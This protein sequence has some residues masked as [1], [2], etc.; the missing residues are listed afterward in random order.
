M[1]STF[2]IS[3]DFWTRDYPD[4]LKPGHPPVRS[5]VYFNGTPAARINYLSLNQ[6]L[7]S[8]FLHVWSQSQ[9]QFRAPKT[10]DELAEFMNLELITISTLFKVSDYAAP[11]VGG[12]S[13]V[14]VI[15]RPPG[16]VTLW[17]Y[18]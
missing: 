17:P 3:E 13:Q 2:T 10:I 7:S 5:W 9:W 8:F 11:L 18:S 4:S 1:Q 6:L 16:A 12:D 14:E 15:R